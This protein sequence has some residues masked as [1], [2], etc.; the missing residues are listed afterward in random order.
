[1]SLRSSLVSWASQEETGCFKVRFTLCLGSSALGLLV[2]K[3]CPDL[4]VSR[5]MDCHEKVRTSLSDA[6]KQ[7]SWPFALVSPEKDI[8][9][10]EWSVSTVAERLS[11][12]ATCISVTSA[13][14]SRRDVLRGRPL[15]VF[16]RRCSG[17]DEAY[18]DFSPTKFS[19]WCLLP[20]SFGLGT[21]PCGV[22]SPVVPSLFW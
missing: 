9:G 13:W 7:M 1:M 16:A 8:C 19:G 14:R 18:T 21:C 12:L 15:F 5:T 22:K 20:L 2:R 3:F 17:G 11:S 6:R 4:Y 10:Y